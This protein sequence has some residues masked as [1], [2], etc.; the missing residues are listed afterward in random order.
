MRPET[1]AA[2][3]ALAPEDQARA[4]IYALLAR[5]YAD[6]P[7]AEL[8]DRLAAS[9]EMVAE[10][11]ETGLAD[12]WNALIAAAGAMDPEAARQEYD[13][14]FVGVGKSPVNLHASH[15]LAGF[16]M[17]RPL[18]E[19]RSNLAALGLARKP[20]HALV[21]DHLASLCET[22]RL[23]I[24]GSERFRPA[25][26]PR[27]EAFFEGH[28]GQWF[29]ECC[30]AIRTCPVANFYSKVAQFTSRFLELEQQAFRVG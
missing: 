4:N 17:E 20:G 19:L 24:A 5:L 7:D 15:Y 21:E 26:I 28:I 13:D 3:D 1:A 25:G 27:Q 29:G 12:A 2:A 16:Q 22:M 30:N 23:L 14:L 10:G 11:S 8:L 6:G 9:D 18:A